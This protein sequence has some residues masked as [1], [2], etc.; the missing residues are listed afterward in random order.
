M[1]IGL[2]CALPQEIDHLRDAMSGCRRE[3]VARLHFDVGELDGHEC[4]LAESGMGKVNAAMVATLMA[5]RFNCRTLVFAGV[6]GGL[7]PDL[8]IGDVVIADVTLQ[9]DAGLI[10]HQALQTYQAG[11]VPAINPTERLGYSA[12]AALLSRVRAK[13]AGVGLPALSSAAGGAGRPPQIRYGTVLTGDQFVQCGAFR[14]R[15]REKFAGLAVE[16]EGAA[17]VQVCESFAI[18]W[19]LIRTLSDLAGNRSLVDFGA[20]ADE[21][22][23]T[24]AAILR[25][26]LPVL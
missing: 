1:T 20:F 25:L 6:A 19:L 4:V 15:L 5:D 21:V 18:P 10:E 13:L 17:V 7:D 9:H 8:S 26:V 23:A 2:I 3:F 22:A 11:H 14:D 24:S 12:D 16:M